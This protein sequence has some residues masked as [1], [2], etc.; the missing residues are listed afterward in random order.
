MVISFKCPMWILPCPV[1][2]KD[3]AAV[4]PQDTWDQAQWHRQDALVSW[5]SALCSSALFVSL[6]VC[7]LCF[8]DSHGRKQ[9]H[10]WP[11]SFYGG[12]LSTWGGLNSQLSFS[13]NPSSKI[14]RQNHWCFN[15]SQMYCPGPVGICLRRAWQ[16]LQQSYRCRAGRK[17]SLI[18]SQLSAR[19]YFLCTQCVSTLHW[20]LKIQWWASK[21]ILLE[22]TL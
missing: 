9:S 8:S 21:P 16:L 5:L 3:K 20:T 11:L 7:C 12:S 10:W 18:H 4:E 2:T 13:L 17:S 14:H 15:V 6:P 19:I 1:D 22:L